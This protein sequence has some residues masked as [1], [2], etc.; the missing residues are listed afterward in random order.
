ML[1]RVAERVYWTGRYVERAESTARLVKA[2]TTQVMDLPKAVEPG[3]KH[4]V[5]ISGA[6]APFEE[7]H[8]GY[9]EPSTIAFL[10]ADAKNPGSI[11]SALAMVRENVRTTRDVLPTE[12]WEHANELYLYA[13]ASAADS[14]GRKNRFSFL[15]TV[16]FRCQQLTGLLAGTMSQDAA[17][18]FVRI[19]RNLERADMTTRV[20]DSAVFILMPRKAEPGEYDSM[21]WVNVL[22]SLSAYQMYRQHVRNRVVADEVVRFL[23]T[24]LYFPRAVAHS[25]AESERCL[26]TLPRSL[27]AL[28]ALA[29]TRARVDDA[30]I[31]RM[32]LDG[33]HRLIDEVQTDLN[34]VHEQIHAAW[35]SLE[36]PPQPEQTQVQTQMQV[37]KQA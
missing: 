23:L 20:V 18:S 22:K 3:W 27:D 30:D 19:G 10:L 8:D 25:L 6:N 32:T 33:L 17:Y 26:E 21:L 36:R 5:D 28:R 1:S 29:R 13:K 35:F 9:D 4:L 34:D 14:V 31:S 2:Y 7:L 16:I 37:Q 15:K 11:L 24:D 12:A